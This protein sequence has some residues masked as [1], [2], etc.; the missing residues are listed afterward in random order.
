MTS[1][2]FESVKIDLMILSI[3]NKTNPIVSSHTGREKC[4]RFTQYFLMFLIPAIQE[5]LK[6]S[7][8]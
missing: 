5:R 1:R 3:L 4:V 8:L 2:M 6:T 7:L